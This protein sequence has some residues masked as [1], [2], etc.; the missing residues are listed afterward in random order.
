MIPVTN[1]HQESLKRH[2]SAASAK[3][4]FEDEYISYKK[5][6]TVRDH[7]HYTGKYRGAV[8]SICNLKY[9]TMDQ[10]I[11]ITLS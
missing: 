2:K 7:C 4:R 3:K 5:H 9:S 10:T 8:H 6:G 1:K 11:I